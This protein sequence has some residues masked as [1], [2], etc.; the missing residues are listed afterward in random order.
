MGNEGPKKKLNI[1]GALGIAAL[2]TSAMTEPAQ[3]DGLFGRFDTV[4]D[5]SLAQPEAPRP[6]PERGPTLR[7]AG[8]VVSAGP[9]EHYVLVTARQD[10]SARNDDRRAGVINEREISVRIEDTDVR[11]YSRDTHDSVFQ[12]GMAVGVVYHREGGEIVIERLE[13]LL[14]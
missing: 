10:G 3:A 6:V 8:T 12:E 1:V 7:G 14:S 2:S 11:F 4:T 13:P 9:W 5:P